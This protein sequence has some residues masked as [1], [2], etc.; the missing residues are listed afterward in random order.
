MENNKKKYQV[1]WIPKT[2]DFFRG[3][4]FPKGDVNESALVFDKHVATLFDDSDFSKQALNSVQAILN[5]HNVEFVVQ[6][7]TVSNAKG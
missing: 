7:L 2:E 3:I 5:S 1:I 6:N 4:S